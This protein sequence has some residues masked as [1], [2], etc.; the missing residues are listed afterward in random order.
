MSFW[1][2]RILSWGPLVALTLISIVII[3]SSYSAIQT[4][5]LHGMKTI[6]ILNFFIMYPESFWILYVYF[7]AM[8]GSGIIQSGW[9]P[10]S[11]K[12]YLHK[13]FVLLIMKLA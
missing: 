2:R 4:F 7:S 11:N 12:L 9:S 3:S 10:V 1:C 13:Y 6:K 8:R 5:G